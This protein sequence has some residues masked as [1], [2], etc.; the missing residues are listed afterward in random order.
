MVQSI[1]ERQEREPEHGHGHAHDHGHGH[2]RGH[3][4]AAG[5]GFAFALA[6]ALTLAFV[7]AETVYGVIGNSVAL[8]A[9]AGH[10]LG[11]ALGLAIAW[12][13]S[14]LAR[15]RPSHRFTYGLRSSSI[16][17][18]LFN[19]IV[20]LIAVGGIIVEALN[21]LAAPE[22]VASRLVMA[23][24]AAGIVV[25]GVT[26]LLFLRGRGGDL[27]IHAAFLHLAA[28]AGVS[29]AVAF[30][31]AAILLTGWLWLDPVASLIVA[32]VIVIG[33]WR[34]LRDA[35]NLALHGVPPGI[36]LGGVR[37]HLGQVAGVVAVHDLHIWPMSTTETALT[38]HLV[39][40]AGHPGDAMLAHLAQELHRRFA[41]DHSTIQVETGDPDHPCKLVP[42]HVV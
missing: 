25:N 37:E 30:T 38:C 29:L 14:V 4:G 26:A 24:A 17:A 31:G 3:G 18:A 19:A 22:P 7:A 10:N 1:A 21:R 6:L 23:I 42:D 33:T 40:P 11:D 15:R 39:M 12:T 5:F 8:L 9:D 2:H 28:D 35:V 13:A 20:L 27:N 16:L 36:D 32:V 41:I 34:L